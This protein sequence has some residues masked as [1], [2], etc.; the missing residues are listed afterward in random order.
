MKATLRNKEASFT[1]NPN[2]TQLSSGEAATK[3]A[4][5]HRA[6]VLLV[7]EEAQSRKGMD[8]AAIPFEWLTNGEHPGFFEFE[9]NQLNTRLQESYDGISRERRFVNSI[10]FYAASAGYLGSYSERM[11]WKVYQRSR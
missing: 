10:G 9:Q 7:V 11:A 1:Q 2:P 3:L 8:A 4:C 5:G 6:A